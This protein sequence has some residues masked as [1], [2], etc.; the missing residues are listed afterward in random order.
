MA[1]ETLSFSTPS[2]FPSTASGDYNKGGYGNNNATWYYSSGWYRLIFL[3]QFTPTKALS[4]LTVTLDAGKVSSQR[5]G[6]GYNRLNHFRCA[7]YPATTAFDPWPSADSSSSGKKID[8]WTYGGSDATSGDI[9]FSTDSAGNAFAAGTKYYL[10]VWYYKEQ[11][12]YYASSG[13][14]TVTGTGTVKTYTVSYNA[15]G[16][17]GAPDSQTKTYGTALT[18]SSTKPTRT[19]Y[20]FQHW[21]TKSDGSGTSYNSGAS[22][23]ANA[24]ATLYAIWQI[25][26]YAVSYNANGGSGAPGSQ[27]KTY[28]V[29][30]TLSTVKPT[31]SNGT[32]S[33]RTVTYDGNS[34]TPARASDTV[35]P[36]RSYSFSKWNTQSGGGGTDYSPGGSYTA[37]AAATLYA[38]WS[39]S[40]NNPTVTLP[41][42]TRTGY[43]LLG[44][45]TSSGA[46]SAQYTAGSSYA[47]S[48]TTTL[49]AVWAINTYAV[50]YNANG[51]SG[52]P[53]AQTK[54]HGVTLTLSSTVPTR[55]G[56]S[57]QGW[58]TSSAGSA[59]YQPGGS[60]TANA[61][62]TLYAVWKKLTY[63]IDY[64]ANGGTGAPASQ[65]KTYGETLKLSTATP[66]RATVDGDTYTVTFNANG[67]SCATASATAQK[68]TTYAFQGWNTKSDG[69]GTSY[70]AGANYTANAAATLYAKWKA[71]T[72]TD[73]VTLPTATR[74]GY[75]FLGWAK[76]A[77]A[78][79][80][81]FTAGDSFTTTGNTTL[82]AVWQAQGLAHVGGGSNFGDCMITIA[83]GS[84][85][86]TYQAY[87]A[88]GSSWKP[89]V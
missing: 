82:Y 3:R 15:N 9:S 7:I 64:N 59:A 6:A 44:W 58:A 85:L 32:G 17:S 14:I 12:T 49:Y 5:Y 18:L 21:N 25:N 20:T 43:H 8:T 67:G 48:A 69:S 16:G 27:T 33:N 74:S 66:S 28:G 73:P 76:T 1:T 4:S 52:A 89:C 47:V 86:R 34:G 46:T 75:K 26:T 41:T 23:T 71:T 24:A 35:T 77:G 22:Y 50:S 55:T 65:T 61:A 83:D 80:A 45:A 84:R 42:A 54:T 39:A 29:A 51:G 38:Q 40:D 56:Y 57:F 13:N 88:D 31:R 60:Y 78:T 70:A 53:A 11:S 30:L 72:A 63:A 37:N 36:V 79:A 87:E 10:Y 62:V 19:G 81:Q 68:R 2:T